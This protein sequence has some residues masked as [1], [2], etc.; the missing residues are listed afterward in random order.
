M[1]RYC[2]SYLDRHGLYNDGFPCPG[3]THC[4]EK[5]D[6]TKMCCPD[7]SENRVEHIVK[8]APTSTLISQMITTKSKFYQDLESLTFN[9]VN[10]IKNRHQ[11]QIENNKQYLS[12]N[13]F[14]RTPSNVS[15]L[16]SK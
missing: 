5:S 13:G 3:Q 2:S 4:C 15:L 16:M 6:G 9:N 8:Q 10:S 11:N 7:M 12:A 1:E 14:A